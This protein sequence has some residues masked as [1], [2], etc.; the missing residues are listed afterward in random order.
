MLEATHAKNV[1][2][3]K[4][5]GRPG[6][7]PLQVSTRLNLLLDS[8]YCTL[9]FAAHSQP[10]T[11]EQLSGRQEDKPKSGGNTKKIEGGSNET[12]SAPSA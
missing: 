2:E 7:F 5:F 4:R 3:E 6:R 8:E 1:R 11:A 10:Q 12:K 9:H